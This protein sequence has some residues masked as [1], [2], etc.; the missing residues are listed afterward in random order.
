MVEKSYLGFP[1]LIDSFIS[2]LE[3][4]PYLM[5]L[6]QG[7]SFIFIWAYCTKENMHSLSIE[8]E[9][10]L[11]SLKSSISSVGM[12]PEVEAIT[13]SVESGI[14]GASRGS[15]QVLNLL[16]LLSFDSYGFVQNF[17]FYFKLVLNRG[18]RGG[19]YKELDEEEREETRRRRREAEE[20]DGEMYDEFGNLKKKFRAKTQVEAGQPLPGA[21][22]AGL[23]VE[24]LGVVDR[25]GRETVIVIMTEIEI[26]GGIGNKIEIEIEIETE[27]GG[28]STV[29]VLVEPLL[30]S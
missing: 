3:L 20:D 6:E 18:G 28:F 2:D 11:L 7:D 15:S 13:L 19:G 5:A 16:H 22:R 26:M 12:A 1:Y 10:L 4:I 8:L 17:L 24:K 30:L 14:S 23:E 21:G 25:G 9:L 29:S 27:V